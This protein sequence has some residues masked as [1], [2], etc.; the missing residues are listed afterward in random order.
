MWLICKE[1]ILA[2][3]EKKVHFYWKTELNRLLKGEYTG[4]PRFT[5]CLE[6]VLGQYFQIE[7]KIMTF[8]F[9]CF[10]VRIIL[11]NLGPFIY[12]I[13][14]KHL[15]KLFKWFVFLMKIFDTLL[16]LFICHIFLFLPIVLLFSRQSCGS[17]NCK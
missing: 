11:C 9:L 10:P 6:L 8:V 3:S 5:F 7:S 14:I 17:K 16:S 12:H 4:K 15:Y 1:I 13:L 2:L